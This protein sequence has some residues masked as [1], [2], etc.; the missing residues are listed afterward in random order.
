VLRY[1]RKIGRTQ[2]NGD[3]SS[4]VS[5]KDDEILVVR[6]M[7]ELGYQVE[8]DAVGELLD[9]EGGSEPVLRILESIMKAKTKQR[10][11]HFVIGSKDVKPFLH[12]NTDQRVAEEIVPDFRVVFD[13][14]GI[15]GP[16]VDTSGYVEMFRSRIEKMSS[17]IR[18][19]PDF[20]QIEK[21]NAIKT[22]T[23]NKKVLAKVVGLVVSKKVT[24]DYTSLTLEDDSG[25]LRLMCTDEAMRKVEDVLI[26]EFVLVEVESLPRGYYA[27]NVYH[28][29]LPERVKRT[30]AKKIYAVFASDLHVGSADFDEAAFL[31]L[32]DWMNGDF[33][34]LE[35]VSRVGYLILNGDLVANP[36][37][38]DGH[39]NQMGVGAYYDMLADYLNRIKRPIKIFIVP[40]ETDASRMALPQPAIIR[41]Y[42]K[43]L[44][45]MKDV[46]ML[47]N[48]SMISLDGVMVLLYHGQGLDDVFRQLQS[49][50]SSKP[51]TGI[52]ALLRA[53]HLAPTYGG[54]TL[55]APEREDLLIV[56]QVPDIVHCGHTGVPDEDT[57]RGT[58]LLSTPSWDVPGKS[59]SRSQGKAALVDLSTFDVL[60]RG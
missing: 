14:T 32:I 33:G 59:A 50:T 39:L 6:K 22:P 53:R 4:M 9:Q 11:K 52:R 27:R 30:S 10:G 7:L 8:L 3:A 56:D 35:I 38:R 60:W 47:G 23:S 36:L 48:P 51:S 24:G 37:S 58:L 34:E 45:E 20:F 25:Y 18:S 31:K 12:T 16:T 5:R 49:T 57:Y 17:I 43:R 26:D 28:P 41:K 55:L 19:R 13:P 1:N 21:L 40:G 29:D 2:N 44:Y 15:I 42:A 46:L 54:L